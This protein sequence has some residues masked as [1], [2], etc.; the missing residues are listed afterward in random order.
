M[1]P[2]YTHRRLLKGKD[3]PL[4][5]RWIWNRLLCDDFAKNGFRV[6]GVDLFNGDPAPVDA[7]E[8]STCAWLSKH[9]TDVTRPR[10]D[11]VIATLKHQGIKEFAATG[12]IASVCIQSARY[13]FDLAFDGIIKVAAVSHPSLLK[14]PE[15]L[16]KFKQTK[17]PLLINSCEIDQVFPIDSQAQADVILGGGLTKTDLY[18]REY[19]DGCTHGFAVRGDMSNPKVKAGKE[20]AFKAIVWFF[21]QYFPQT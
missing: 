20:G 12:Y 7:M 16:H 1:L 3:R 4:P 13:V 14:I 2:R 10:I 15:D 9:G 6:V 19:F 8:A 18:R 11:N 17:V 5:S 21:L